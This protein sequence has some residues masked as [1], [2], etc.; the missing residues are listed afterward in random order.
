MNYV[1]IIIAVS[2]P[3]IHLALLYDARQEQNS[4][5][6]RMWQIQKL[7]PANH[8]T[9]LYSGTP[10]AQCQRWCGE[11][12]TQELCDGWKLEKARRINIRGMCPVCTTTCVE[13]CYA[14]YQ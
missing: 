2:S 4:T 12:L 8:N 10:E 11:T 1:R 9:T 6:C 3:N 7:P 14:E 5:K 13:D